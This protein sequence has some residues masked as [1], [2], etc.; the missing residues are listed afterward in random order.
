VKSVGGKGLEIILWTK[1]SYFSH[2]FERRQHGSPE[3]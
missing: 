1:S 3:L 2:N